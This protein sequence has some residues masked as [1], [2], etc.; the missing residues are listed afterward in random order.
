MPRFVAELLLFSHYAVQILVRER[1]EQ[2]VIDSN[3]S[4]GVTNFFNDTSIWKFGSVRSSL[5]G[6]G[7]ERS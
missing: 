1:Q 4:D 6:I 3:I 7:A 5:S 2:F